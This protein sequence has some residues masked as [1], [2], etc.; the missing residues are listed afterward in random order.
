MLTTIQACRTC[1]STLTTR[2]YKLN[3][4]GKTQISSSRSC[5]QIKDLVESVQRT[6]SGRIVSLPNLHYTERLVELGLESLRHRRLRFDLI[7]Y[8]KM[9]NDLTLIT[10]C[11]HLLIHHSIHPFRLSLPH[12]QKLW[13]CYSKLSSSVVYKLTLGLI[14]LVL[15]KLWLL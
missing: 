12:L 5:K 6:F 7:N 2:L 11:D 4:S 15:S 14:C 9:L 8:S 10:P 13:R 1:L 3:K